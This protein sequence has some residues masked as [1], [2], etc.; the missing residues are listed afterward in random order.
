MAGLISGSGEAEK[1]FVRA[2]GFA[3]RL[4]YIPLLASLG[5]VALIFVCTLVS[6]SWP[7]P[8]DS[9]LMHYIGFLIRSGQVP[10]RDIID[11]NLPVSYLPDMVL[12]AVPAWAPLLWRLFDLGLVCGVFWGFSRVAGRSGAFAA[13][14][15]GGLFAVV[16]LR[17]GIEQAGERD[18]TAGLVLLFAVVIL[19]RAL[20][21]GGSLRFF[22][23]GVW[24]GVAA[25]I[26]PTLS[27]FLLLA[28]LP[29]DHGSAGWRR[30]AW[31]VAGFAAPVCFVL[32]WLY[33]IGAIPAFWYAMGVLA[34]YHASLGRLGF[35]RLMHVALSP[36]FPMVVAWGLVRAARFAGYAASEF[37][38]SL[39]LERRVLAAGAVLGLLSLLLQ[40]KGLPYQRYPFLIFALL[41]ITVELSA[42]LGKRTAAGWLALASLIW[43]VGVFTPVSL[44]KASRYQSTEGGFEASL[45]Q[46]LNGLSGGDPQLLQQNVQCIDSIS[47]C[48]ATLYRMQI[49]QSTGEIYDEFLFNRGAGDERAR[50]LN[51]LERRPPEVLVVSGTLFPSGPDGYAKLVEWPEFNAWLAQRYELA[52]E[53]TMAPVRSVGRVVA[54]AG[55]RLY[56]LRDSQLAF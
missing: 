49:V 17:D 36:I 13:A 28:C 24:V 16:H 44:Y 19:L 39:R 33:R 8:A 30:A 56:L 1:P 53:R 12:G 41:A 20:R 5:S 47:G 6:L 7:L 27:P 29:V 26:K 2:L 22:W 14:W 3:A 46:D 45:M 15:A 54:P 10:Y 40:G 9:A 52:Q 55:Y 42:Q 18:L 32:A 35:G 34:P 25:L 11:V 51:S 37:D 31:C 21:E 48:V 43:G 50:L 4:G 23:F 38:D